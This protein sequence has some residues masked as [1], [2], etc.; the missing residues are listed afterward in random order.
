MG[1]TLVELLV[2][3]AIIGVLI[4]L[5]LPAVQAAREAARRTQCTNN[6]KQIGLATLNYH[7]AN[8]YLPPLRLA[9]AQ[10]TYLML[11]LDYMEEPNVKGL[12]DYD[13]GC[14]YDQR[15]STRIAT[16]DA[17]YCPSM[18]H[19]GRILIAKDPPNDGH[20]HNSQ[21]PATGGGWEGS[22]ADYRGTS[23]SSLPVFKPG[24]NE[25]LA[26]WD[27]LDT[28]RAMHLLDGAIVAA[29]SPVEGGPSGRGI[30]SFKHVV[31]MR[32]ITDGTSK[33]TLCGEVGRGTSERGH[34]F[35]GDMDWRL[36]MGDEAPFCERCTVPFDPDPNIPNSERADDGFGGAHTGIV[37]F[38]FCDG[39]VQSIPRDI[40]PKI[41]DCMATRAGGEIYDIE[42]GAFSGLREAPSGGGGGGF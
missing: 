18:P 13:L 19:D 12:W 22:L 23:R 16:V 40:E 8:R 24:T 1:F 38:A 9:D 39:H 3:I 36:G 4:A 37:N 5:L 20:T 15:H 11:I 6:L 31:S 10:P 33:T 41:L 2:V 7:D 17:Y 27:K 32:K 28:L 26:T 42:S 21:D 34:A 14:F 30:V 35:N 29:K 25:V